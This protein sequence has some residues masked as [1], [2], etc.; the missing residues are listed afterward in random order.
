MAWFDDF[1]DDIETSLGGNLVSVELEETDYRY[2]L[3]TAIRKYKQYGAN[4]YRHEYYKV[5]MTKGQSV[6]DDLPEEIHTVVK[7]LRPNMN[8]DFFSSEDLFVQ[9]AIDSMFINAGR[10][11]LGCG[12]G[13]FLEYEMMLQH[14]ERLLRYGAY[15]VDFN[16]NERSKKMTVFNKPKRDESW[17]LE[18][19]CDITEQEYA[20]LDWVFEWTKSE[21]MIILGRAYG[22]F[23]GGIAGPNGDVN[24]DGNSLIQEAKEMQRM[25]MEDAQ[26]NMSGGVDSYGIMIG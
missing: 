10:A 8:S 26:N 12:G 25:L 19:Y 16:F 4:N 17:F 5:D 22:K 3:R 20:Q 9:K 24:L 6:I 23:N 18:V 15:D 1:K 7:V 11:R 14:Q 13:M 2:G 21:V